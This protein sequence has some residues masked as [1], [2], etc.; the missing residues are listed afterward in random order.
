M[1][2]FSSS[3]YLGLRHP[4]HAL[5]PWEALTTGRPAA[6]GPPIADRRVAGALARLVGC[7]HAT[8]GPSTLHLFWDLLGLLGGDR[9][10]IY[11][12]A[13]AYPVAGWG[14]GRL[15]ARGAPVRVFRH[16]DPV[17]LKRW[18]T[19]DALL[20]RRPV[21]VTD[22]LCPG[23]GGVA[24]LAAYRAALGPYRGYLVVDDT[25]ALGIL[26]RLSHGPA[27]PYGHGGGGSLRFSGIS[28]PDIVVVSSLAK[29][30]GVPLAVLAGGRRL[31][32][33]FESHSS[34]RMH[35]SP[36]S[37][38]AV[39][40]AEHALR[41]NKAH[42]NALRSLLLQLVRR[43]KERLTAL[44]LATTS[45]VFPVQ[46]LAPLPGLDPGAVHRQLLDWGIRSVMHKPRC[47][48]HAAVSFLIT[49]L[50]HFAD[51]ERAARALAKAVRRAGISTNQFT[52]IKHEHFEC[53]F[54]AV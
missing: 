34:T 40:A 9:A 43:F 49:T 20:R 54:R 5:R 10:A 42:G 31:V 15:A 32:A 1:L 26:G 6:L 22:G 25:Q 45:G 48:P 30:F 44:G 18:L 16:H 12:D 13:G 38:A 27:V 11:L 51:V 47:R 52:G 36:P 3:L 14:A 8:L 17:S 23:C 46:T 4:V 21:I 19:R 37:A 28:G 50:H 33:C 24:P 29:A 35:S 41:I 53:G 2:D 7:D 39:H